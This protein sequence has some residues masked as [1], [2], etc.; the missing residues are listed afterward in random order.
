MNTDYYYLL[1]YQ[2]FKFSYTKY[3]FYQGFRNLYFNKTKD[4]W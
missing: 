4:L 2:K 3:K 1:A